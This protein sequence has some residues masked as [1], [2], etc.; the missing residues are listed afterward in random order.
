MDNDA[1]YRGFS[2][3]SVMCKRNIYEW[4]CFLFIG[5][6]LFIILS[7]IFQEILIHDYPVLIKI[8]LALLFSCI[9]LYLYKRFLILYYDDNT[10]PLVINQIQKIAIGWLVI[11][12]FFSGTIGVLYFVNCYTPEKIEFN[13]YSQFEGLSIFG[14]VAVSEEIICRGVI[15][16]L[17]CD[18]WNIS[19]GVIV[20]SALFGI[21]HIFNDGATIWSALAIAVTSGWLLAIA[22]TYHGTIWVP[23]GM[24]WAWNYLEGC[25]FGCLVSG[26]VPI[27]IP[28]IT[29][30]I[31]GNGILTGGAFGP[32]ASI[33]V[34]VMGA[35]ISAAY[36]MLYF[37]S[38]I[39]CKA[40]VEIPF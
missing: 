20:S 11:S 12:A 39:S 26:Q 25:I 3:M 33:V 29:P 32:E 7:G 22:Y 2:V 24:H 28:L 35:I 14:I 5:V 38:K 21:M 37:K 9:L 6:M 8:L 10:I 19:V 40:V 18:R 30:S 4:G 1:P 17:I 23:I 31:T 16:R 34:V 36:T 27:G 15:Y 13:L